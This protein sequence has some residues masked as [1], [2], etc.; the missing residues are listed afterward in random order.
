MKLNHPISTE[1]VDPLFAWRDKVGKKLTRP[2]LFKAFDESHPDIYA[3]FKDIAL[4]LIAL[5]KTRYSADAVM[6]VVRFE[7]DTTTQGDAFKINNYW[8]AFY[9][10]KFIAE[11]PK[12]A[13]FF[14]TR[15]SEADQKEGE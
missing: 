15:V 5:G 11:F 6:H 9:A 13:A 3:R 12:H 7:R 10:R 1:P 14:E 8:T 2:E 4:H